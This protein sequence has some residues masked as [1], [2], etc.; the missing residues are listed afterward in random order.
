MT[1]K[2]MRLA[3]VTPRGWPLADWHRIEIA[4]AS[5]NTIRIG[6][7]GCRVTGIN[8]NAMAGALST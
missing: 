1:G 7:W 3:L 2:P 4:P 8:E 6:D 5:V